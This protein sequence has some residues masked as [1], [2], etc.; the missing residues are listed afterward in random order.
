MRIAVAS[1]GL[2]VS[3]TFGHCASFTCYKIE[4][5]VITECQ[6]M[7]NPLIPANQLAAMFR[8]LDVSVLL[9]GLIEREVADSL[10][11]VGIDV[12]SNQ[13]GTA[14]GAA[15][16]YLARTLTGADDELE[17]LEA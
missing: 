4:R 13:S 10:R 9:V 12:I 6:N 8:E 14:R 11:A 7:P 3:P 15:Q 5:G 16:T 2:G 17:I 1:K